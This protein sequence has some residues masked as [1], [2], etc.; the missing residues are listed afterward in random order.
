MK[1]MNTAIA[2]IDEYLAPLAPDKRAALERLRRTIREAAPKAVEAISY[3]MPAFKLNG[4][5]LVYFGA[6]A[7]HCSFYPGSATLVDS[8][9]EDLSGYSTSKGTIRFQAGKPLPAPLVKRIVK[10]RMKENEARRS[11]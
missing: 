4:K 5:A 3:G 7:K 9:S 1:R 10:A 8:M 6:A 2:T 11:A